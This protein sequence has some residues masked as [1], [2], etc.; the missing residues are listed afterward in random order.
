MPSGV[1]IGSGGNPRPPL[2]RPGSWWLALGAS[3][4]LLAGLLTALVPYW[5]SNDDVGM[6][7]LAHGFGMAAQ[8]S[9]RLIFSNVVW[10]WLVR[11]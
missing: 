7:M 4:L 10:G 1:N 6:A 9:P 3:L 2:D 8:A 5:E 11:E